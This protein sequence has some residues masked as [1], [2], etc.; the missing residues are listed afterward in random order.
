MEAFCIFE[1]KGAGNGEESFPLL[2][3]KRFRL[4]RIVSRGQPT[5][6][7]EW[8]D[9]EWPEWVLLASGQAEIIFADTSRV[10]LQAGDWLMIPAALRH[11]VE[12][13]SCDAVW[14]ALHFES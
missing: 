10:S 3:G 12:R 9:Q 5:P 4:E 1:D 7:G 6:E 13:V 2:A 11:R 14:L 8:Y